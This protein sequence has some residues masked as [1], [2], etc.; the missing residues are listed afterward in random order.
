MRSIEKEISDMR[1]SS[2]SDTPPQADDNVTPPI[3]KSSMSEN[4]RRL[5]D[6]VEKINRAWLE[7]MREM[8]RAQAEFS[9]H[10]FACKGASDALALC[11]EWMAKRLE[12]IQSEQQVFENAWTDL[13][14]LL[15]K[16]AT[17]ADHKRD[18]R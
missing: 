16:N 15:G 3:D 12:I 10:L 13:I 14:S 11:N 8:R 9:I 4:R 2:Y 7:S 6:H 5:F 1:S 18:Q 17:A